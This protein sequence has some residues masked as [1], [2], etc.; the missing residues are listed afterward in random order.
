M[1]LK[2]KKLVIIAGP[3]ASGKTQVSIDIAKGLE[4]QIISADSMLIYKRMNIGTA[5]PNRQEMQGIEHHLIDIVEPWETYTVSDYENDAL[6]I[7]NKIYDNNS[8]PL[9]CGG[10]G[11]YI[12]ALINGTFS[13][14]A[15][16]PEVRKKLNEDL[17]NGKTLKQLHSDLKKIDPQTASRVHENDSYRI[18]R[19]LEVYYST[20]K[21]MSYFRSIHETAKNT[22]FKPLI[23]VLSPE[24]GILKERIKKRTTKMF[25]DGLLKEVKELLDAGCSKELKPMKSI[26]YKQAIEHLEGLMSLEE[27]MENIIKETTALAK[28][29]ITWFKKRDHTKWIDPTAIKDI[30][31]EIKNFL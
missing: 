13:T 29:Q 20:G 3:T 31:K 30:Q 26:G 25:Q 9:I 18:F 8:T 12:N 15:P 2:E 28:R 10:T 16:S 5:K 4:A 23:I 7:I 19:A 21:S 22:R 11:F 24:K 27:A 1:T 14:P 6:S 17:K